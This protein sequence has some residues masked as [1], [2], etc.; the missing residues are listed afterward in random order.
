MKVTLKALRVNFGLTQKEM[1]EVIG[2]SVD[3]WRNYENGITVPSNNIVEKVISTFNISYDDIVF[4]HS[5]RLNS[6]SA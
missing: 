3:S 2:C 1:A 4:C 5:L 6:I